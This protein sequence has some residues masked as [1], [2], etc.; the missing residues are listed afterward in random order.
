MNWHAFD[1]AFLGS[2][3]QCM[4]QHIK[5]TMGLSHGKGASAWQT[6]MFRIVF[7]L[8]SAT[9]VAAHVVTN[10]TYTD[11]DSVI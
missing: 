2:S 6:C 4:K 9:R 5:P 1:A 8:K 11:I 10:D 3:H 7:D